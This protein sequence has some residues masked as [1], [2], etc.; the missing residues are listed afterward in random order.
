L[1]SARGSVLPSAEAE[2]TDPEGNLVKAV[3][4]VLEILPR[5]HFHRQLELTPAL[6]IS[7]Q[8]DPEQFNVEIIRLRPPPGLP[9][10]AITT[11]EVY[12]TVRIDAA[13]RA[14]WAGDHAWAARTFSEC[15]FD[16]HGPRSVEAAA[17]EDEL[18]SSA[19]LLAVQDPDCRT[20]QEMRDIEKTNARTDGKRVP[21]VERALR[22]HQVHVS[23][24]VL[25]RT[26]KLT[27]RL[28]RAQ[29]S[30]KEAGGSAERRREFELDLPREREV[31]AEVLSQGSWRLTG[32][33][34]GD[35]LVV[36]SFRIDAGLDLRRVRH[37]ALRLH[38]HR[39]RY[40]WHEGLEY[41][42]F[43]DGRIQVWK[44]EGSREAKHDLI[45]MVSDLLRYWESG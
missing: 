23:E 15:G 38:G 42:V 28:L 18:V 9:P 41:T 12:D 27:S 8:V 39:A 45:V 22:K 36:R 13:R 43:D 7:V 26:T 33:S 29:E 40:G 2:G 37:P 25:T 30:D 34:R 20:A 32:A 5:W 3:R 6:A 11:R 24:D 44:P 35:G 1:V 4:T 16:T 17:L 10:T 21:A 31:V 19:A 14:T